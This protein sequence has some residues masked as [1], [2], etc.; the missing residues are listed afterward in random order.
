MSHISD[1]W[2]LATPWI[3]PDHRTSDWWASADGRATPYERFWRLWADTTRF[4]AQV[5]EGASSRSHDFTKQNHGVNTTVKIFEMFA[6]FSPAVWIPELLSSA[7]I[8]S[9]PVSDACWSYEFEASLGLTRSFKQP[10][11]ALHI[12]FEDGTDNLI[13]IEAKRP[14]DKLKPNAARP[15]H[16]PSSYLDL[17]AFTPFPNRRMIYLV[18]QKYVDTVHNL[19]STS[20]DQRWSIVTWQQVAQMQFALIR[21]CFDAHLARIMAKLAAWFTAESSMPLPYAPNEEGFKDLDAILRVTKDFMRAESGKGHIKAVLQGIVSHLEWR[22]SFD[23]R[24]DCLTYLEAEPS[25]SEIDTAAKAHRQKIIERR[26]PL[27]MLPNAPTSPSVLHV[28]R[29]QSEK[30]PIEVGCPFLR[31]LESQSLSNPVRIRDLP[32]S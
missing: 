28:I 30:W 8:T 15:D 25:M 26:W 31:F 21:K 11:V 18:D 6:L 20:G 14:G 2:F 12:L 32:F 3:P 13:L 24:Q 16:L 23:S 4:N 19:V 9:K 22:V 29:K 1:Y 5:H 10:D 17:D 7:G 27:W